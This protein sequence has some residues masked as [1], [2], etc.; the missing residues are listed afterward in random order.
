MQKGISWLSC[1][2]AS[3]LVLVQDGVYGTLWS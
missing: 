2:L 3:A 1:R